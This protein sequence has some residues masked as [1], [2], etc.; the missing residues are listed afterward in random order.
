M[1]TKLFLLFLVSFVFYT[2]ESQET[3]EIG[4]IV[5]CFK[6][7]P[8]NNVKISAARS[9]NNVLTDPNGQFEIS[10]L[11][12]DFLHVTASGFI[13]KKVKTGKSNLYK[14]NLSYRDN[15]SNF[16]AAIKNNHI[17][18][19]VLQKVIYMN[20]SVK[21]KDYS[22]YENIFDLIDNE[23]Y[24]LRVNGTS[25]TNYKIRSFNT[26][27]QVLYVVNDKIVPDISY[28]NTVD[29][30][31]I[32]FIDDVRATLYGSK[33]ANGVLKITLK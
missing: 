28:I 3:K 22:R 18:E 5:T 17:G 27:P 6:N 20:A 4:G 24:N 13:E 8:L 15:E 12:K 33:G 7:I 2:G 25:V 32:E 9:G 26:S 23:I 30:K 21:P 16:R 29:V 11:T 10:V 19:D 14:I 31:S 1:K